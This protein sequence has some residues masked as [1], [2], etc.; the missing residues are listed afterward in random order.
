MRITTR[1]RYALR[2]MANLAVSRTSK[3]KS[4]RVIAEEEEISP[5]FLE[6]IFFRL[7]K[8]GIVASTRGPGGGFRLVVDPAEITVRQIFDAVDEGINLTPCSSEE[9]DCDRMDVC[10]V[11]DLW[12]EASEHFRSYFDAISLQDIMDRNEGRPYADMLVTG[13]VGSLRD[14]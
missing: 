8:S 6:Q 9:Q 7:K 12:R 4:I 5:E 3:P 13:E 2:A 11:H 14:S 1:G 10:L